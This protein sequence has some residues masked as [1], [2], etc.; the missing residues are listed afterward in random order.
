M[1]SGGDPEVQTRD[2]LPPEDLKL[3]SYW[4][5]SELLTASVSG[6]LTFLS[7]YTFRLSSRVSQRCLT[8]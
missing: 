2:A 7:Y 4:I 5:V 3:T 6:E 8:A 1:I